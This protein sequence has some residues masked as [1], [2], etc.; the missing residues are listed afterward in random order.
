M[1]G[2]KLKEIEHDPPTAIE[3]EQ[4]PPVPGKV[5]PVKEY[6]FPTILPTRFVATDCPTFVR[7]IDLEVVEPVPETPKPTDWDGDID[8]TAGDRPRPNRPELNPT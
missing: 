5:P 3:L 7:V 4:F 8:R 1:T 6:E 2:E